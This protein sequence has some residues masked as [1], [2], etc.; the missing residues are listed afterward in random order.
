MKDYKLNLTMIDDVADGR[1]YTVEGG[2]LV[3]APLAQV[4]AR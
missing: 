4:W 3:T 1:V 2:H